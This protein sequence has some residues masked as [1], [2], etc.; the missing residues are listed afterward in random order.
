[1][2]FTLEGENGTAIEDLGSG[3]SYIGYDSRIEETDIVDLSPDGTYQAFVTPQNSDDNVAI[4]IDFDDDGVFGESERVA[5]GEDLVN[6]EPSPVIIHLGPT[7]NQG[8]HRMRVMLGWNVSPES[9]DPCNA[10]LGLLYGEIQDYEVNIIEGPSCLS[11][12]NITVNDIT[13]SSATI[14]WTDNNEGV[15]NWTFAYGPEGV[16][17]DNADNTFTVEDTPEFS[18]DNLDA[19]TV[20]QVYVRANCSPGSEESVW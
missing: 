13:D 12:S 14:S 5:T 4:W 7:V 8:Q 18:M 6:G 17:P 20:Y 11:P 19:Y 3:C 15:S 16:D 1:D 10:G 9:F 2:D